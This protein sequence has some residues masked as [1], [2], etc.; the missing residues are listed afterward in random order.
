MD[1]HAIAWEPIP[2]DANHFMLVEVLHFE[3]RTWEDGVP[4]SIVVTSTTGQAA[5]EEEGCA[6]W[7]IDF[8]TV[9]AFQRREF[10]WW[11]PEARAMTTPMPRASRKADANLEVATWEVVHSEWLKAC[12]PPDTYSGAMH[13]YV[14]AAE[15]AAYEIAALGWTAERLPLGWK[16]AYGL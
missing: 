1:E 7:R 14:I 5:K 15:D 11:W 10:G 2:R 6:A 9:A 16:Q 4:V 13:H 3:E 8:V 12:V